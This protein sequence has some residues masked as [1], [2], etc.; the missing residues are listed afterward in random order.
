MRGVEPVAWSTGNFPRENE[1]YYTL[2]YAEIEMRRLTILL[3]LVLFPLQAAFAAGGVWCSL[4]QKRA[5]NSA[6][7]T[8]LQV[9]EHHAAPH[10]GAGQGHVPAPIPATYDHGACAS[11]A[12]C[13]G[14]IGLIH[15]APMFTAFADATGADF[16][17]IAVRLAVAP[18]DGL[19]RPPRAP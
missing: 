14:S 5:V 8:E 10:D 4:A 15:L 18:R 12:P 17:P 16:P 7:A 2:C 11:C 19:E 3:L 13:C 9:H 6:A 1:S